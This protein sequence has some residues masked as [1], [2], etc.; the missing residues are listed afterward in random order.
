VTAPSLHQV[1][2][3]GL[4]SLPRVNLIPPEIA[5]RR[6]LRRVQ[7]GLGAGA[8]A[9]LAIVVVLLLLASASV[10][11]AKVQLTAAQA[12]NTKVQA[13]VDGLQNVVKTFALVDQARGALRDA[14]GGE[15]LWSTYFT[16]LSLRVPANV[17]ITKLT[18]SSVVASAAGVAG[19]PAGVALISFEGVGL[20][21]NDVATWLDSI[22]KEHGWS[23]P[24]SSKSEEKVIN[25]RVVY[26]FASTVTVTADALSGRY[27]KPAVN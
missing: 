8:V 9:A 25:G 21:H 27:T 26:E 4:P 2:T 17:W 13:Q 19:A 7:A 14:A 11:S 23:N 20:A 16:D 18:V 1:G 5:A 15:I 3:A 6:T 22:A 12:D 24:Y 10:S